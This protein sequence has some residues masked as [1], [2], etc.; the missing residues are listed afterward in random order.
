R[1]GADT[2]SKSLVIGGDNAT[3]VVDLFVARP[4]LLVEDRHLARM[5]HRGADKPESAGSANRRTKALEI[6]E[7]R[8]RSNKA[9]RHDAGATGGDDRHLLWH[10]QRLGIGRDAGRGGEI[11]GA[12]V[13][14]AEARVGAGNLG[15][16]K[17]SRGRFDHRDQARRPWRHAAFGLYL[18]DDL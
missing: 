3:G 6:M 9:Q 17:K 18:F 1:D 2:F 14:G 11:L 7:I 10:R 12:E 16:A 8:D 15:D 4:E 5:D 13:E